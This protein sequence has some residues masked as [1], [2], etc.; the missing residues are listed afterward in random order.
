MADN[1]LQVRLVIPQQL[2]ANG[3]PMYRVAQEFFAAQG[4]PVFLQEKLLKLSKSLP[5]ILE[6]LIEPQ[7][8]ESFLVTTPHVDSIIVLT[9]TVSRKAARSA[10]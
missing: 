9:Q 1:Q 3:R 7:A 5:A 10:A 2:K 8:L 4:S 6:G